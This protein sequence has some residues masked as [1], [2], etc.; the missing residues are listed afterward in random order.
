VAFWRGGRNG[1]GADESECRAKPG[2]IEKSHVVSLY[3]FGLK[4]GDV[5]RFR[6]VLFISIC[7]TCA[8]SAQQTQQILDK[9]ESAAMASPRQAT[10][11]APTLNDLMSRFAAALQSYTESGGQ[12]VTL[13]H[14]IPG[15]GP[16]LAGKAQLVL[17]Q[18]KLNEKF[19]TAL[20]G[21]TDRIAALE[22]DLNFDDDVSFVLTIGPTAKKGEKQVEKALATAED[23]LLK[24]AVADHSDGITNESEATME[25]ARSAAEPVLTAIQNRIATDDPEDFEVFDELFRGGDSES[26]DFRESFRHMAPVGNQETADEAVGRITN[27]TALRKVAEDITKGMAVLAANQ[28]KFTLDASYRD[29]HE[30]AGPDEWF[31]KTSYEWGVG[32]NVAKRIEKTSN[33]ACAQT[34]RTLASDASCSNAYAQA[35]KE[36]AEDG[37]VKMGSRVTFALEYKEFSKVNLTEPVAFELKGSH[38][39]T[40]SLAAGRDLFEANDLDK[41]GRIEL[42]VAYNDVRDDNDPTKN[43][44]D[45]LIGKLTYS[46]R[47]TDKI[48]LPI[49]LTYANHD[50]YLTDVD[51]KLS[52]HFGISYKLPDL[53]K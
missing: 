23:A 5:M 22:K 32:T 41:R 4:E 8:L 6:V 27:L 18:P 16:R 19:V 39:L 11:T 49:S 53:T 3:F 14:K 36:A 48:D 9:S 26:D 17:R 42:S 44:K 24:L 40:Y 7:I 20:S 38:S 13:E 51:R 15:L 21:Q 33:R 50:D 28:S 37:D 45:R 52:A 43:R 10:G 31:V 29:R 47:L 35:L 2:L 34:Y 25:R 1:A 46:Q 12:A 30:M